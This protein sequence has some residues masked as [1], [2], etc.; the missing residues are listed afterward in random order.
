MT[1][2]AVYET[3]HPV[4]QKANIA[5]LGCFFC[6]YPLKCFMIIGGII[7]KMFTKGTHV[8]LQNKRF[9]LLYKMSAPFFCPVYFTFS[10]LQ[11]IGH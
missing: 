10:P 6:R 2:F 3:V 8:S 11:I 5:V 1:Y 7:K 9:P 4:L